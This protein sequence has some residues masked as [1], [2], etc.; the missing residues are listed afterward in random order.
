V[1]LEIEEASALERLESRKIDPFTGKAYSSGHE[2][3]SQEIAQRL[4]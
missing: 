2:P 1:F 4:I 3:D